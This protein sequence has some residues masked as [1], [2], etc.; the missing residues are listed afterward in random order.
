MYSTLLAAALDQ[1]QDNRPRTTAEALAR[2]WQHRTN[3]GSGRQ[4][5]RTSHEAF[6]G[7]LSYDVA[8]IHLARQFDLSCDISEFDRSD[9]ARLFLETRLMS[10]GVQLDP[11]CNESE[12]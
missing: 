11:P 1:E 3:A 5:K 9:V 6:I 4:Q 10:L 7:C 8:L 2:L 12:A